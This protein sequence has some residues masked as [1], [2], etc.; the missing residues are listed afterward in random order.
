VGLP[1]DVAAFRKVRAAC[2]SV[3]AAL[4]AR[5]TGWARP[6]GVPVEAG[7]ADVAALRSAVEAAIP[8]PLEADEVALGRWSPFLA[9]AVVAGAGRLGQGKSAPLP[10]EDA[11][12]FAQRLTGAAFSATPTVDGAPAEAGSLCYVES[13][14]AMAPVL[15]RAGRTVWARLLGQLANAHRLLD[16]LE[17]EL[18]RV[19]TGRSARGGARAQ[20][21]GAGAGVADTSRGRLAHAVELEGG[22][23]TSWRTVA[24]T[25]WTFHP[26]GVVPQVLEGLRSEEAEA[27][28]PFLVAGLDPCV[29]CVVRR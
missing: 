22:V 14:P 26:Q 16:V 4:I 13:M 17:A 10:L 21:A 19:A 18:P 29:A 8:H 20:G 2:Q 6:G 12:W 1:P 7:V 23:V 3:R 5:T 9:A 24:P 11:S 15:A 25:E 27:L 28:A